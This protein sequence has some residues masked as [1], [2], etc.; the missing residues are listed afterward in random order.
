MSLTSY[1]AAPPRAGCWWC[2]ALL[3]CMARRVPLLCSTRR[4]DARASRGV[5]WEGLAATDFP[6]PWGTVSWALAVFTSEFGMGSGV[7][8]PPWPPGRL[9]QPRA[10]RLHWRVP[11]NVF[12]GAFGAMPALARVRF[13]HECECVPAGGGCRAALDG[14]CAWR[15]CFG[16]LRVREQAGLWGGMSRSGD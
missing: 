7:G 12:V 15:A 11:R 5:G 16:G 4:A 14:C 8:P 9:S 3:L 1:R 13:W 10:M 6:V 2:V